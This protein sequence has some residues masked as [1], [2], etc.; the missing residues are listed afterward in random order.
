MDG[1]LQGRT[2]LRDPADVGPQYVQRVKR[3]KQR[4]GKEFQLNTQVAGFQISD[5]MLDLGSDVN[6]LPRK[7][8][9]ALG[10]PRLAYSPIQ[11]RMVNQYCI[12]PIGWLEGVE[13]DVAGVK[14]YTDFEVID[15]MGDKDPYPTL[16]GID[17][18][19]ENYSIID[20]KKELMIFEDGEVRVTQPLDPYQ[21]PRYTKMVDNREDA[22]MMDHL[23]QM[24][25]GKRDDYIKPTVTGSVSWQSLQSSK[26]GSELAWED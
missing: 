21:G 20:L 2:K 10:R 23:Y 8:W 3:N 9:Q 14:T 12:F 1:A 19:F 26:L 25:A 11:L 18:A 7:T 22:Q 4:T 24:I 13:V 15:I 5:T 17:W 16:L 6:I